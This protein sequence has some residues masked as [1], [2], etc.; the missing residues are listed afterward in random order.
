MPPVLSPAVGL[1]LC[2]LAGAAWSAP[3]DALLRPWPEASALQA[4]EPRP[5]GF[6]SA[7]PFALSDVDGPAAEPLEA[8]HRA[9]GMLFLPETAEAASPVPAVVLL[10]GARGVSQARELTY[11]RQ[12][13]AMGLAALVIDVFA[14]RRELASSFTERLIEITE[15]M[16]LADAFAAIA[17][18]GARPEIDG[19][20]IALIG[21]SY[22]GMAS[23]YA[24]HSQVAQ[25]YAERFALG[26]ARPFKAHVAFYAPCIARFEDPS[27]TGAPVLML[28]GDRDALI[29]AERCAEVADDL[30]S[31]GAEVATRVFE[32]GYHQWDGS[33]STPWRAPR[34]L[35]G[36]DFRVERDG[37]VRG[38]LPGTPF[39]QA[40]VDSFTRKL[41][42]ALCSDG[43]GYLVGRDREIRALSNRVLGEFLAESLR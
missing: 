26:K 30:R 31:G 15:A 39:R 4:I 7:S 22:G 38:A 18:L 2:C 16:V 43:E 36:C 37:T 13:A 17:A 35:A 20:R 3:L 6:P 25:L 32:G 29:D 28:W 40:M 21:F 42:L 10:H 33:L 41:I 12:F 19:D 8:A 1:L 9:S 23:L 11:G 24:A 5:F 34:G 27:A 14:S